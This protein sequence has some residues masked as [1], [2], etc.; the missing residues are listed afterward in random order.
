M[1]GHGSQSGSVTS[2]HH[3]HHHHDSDR[4]ISNPFELFSLRKRKSSH[5]A[6]ESGDSQEPSDQRPRIKS[7]NTAPAK[8]SIG[9]GKGQ[10]TSL[11]G[12]ALLSTVSDNSIP[13]VSRKRTESGGKHR[14]SSLFGKRHHHDEDASGPAAA[15]GSQ[16]VA[17][18]I[19]EPPA[20]SAETGEAE[21]TEPPAEPRKE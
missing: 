17:T 1:R 8:T 12:S 14:I 11:L 6:A 20:E 19:M 9:H 10:R 18:K 3:H 7:N 13:T 2:V 4:D 5:K 15:E 21:K 16:K